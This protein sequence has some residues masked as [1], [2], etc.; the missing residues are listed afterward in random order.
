[1]LHSKAREV[2]RLLTDQL[3][4]QLRGH[5][6]SEYIEKASNML[7]GEL[8]NRLRRRLDDLIRRQLVDD[9]W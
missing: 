2:N 7:V 6:Y 4:D 8:D 1:M 5:W 9:T 3:R